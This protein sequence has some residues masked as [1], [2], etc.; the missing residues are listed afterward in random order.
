MWTCDVCQTREFHNYEAAISHEKSC[1]GKDKV[2]RV[3]EVL[4]HMNSSSKGVGTSAS[5]SASANTDS[6]V[7]ANTI[8]TATGTTPSSVLAVPTSTSTSTSTTAPTIVA[9]PPAT[10]PAL[11]IYIPPPIDNIPKGSVKPLMGNCFACDVCKKAYFRTYEDAVLHEDLCQKKHDR[12]VALAKYHKVHREFQLQQAAA[13]EVAKRKADA[14]EAAVISHRESLALQQ[15]AAIRRNSNGAN[16]NANGKSSQTQTQTPSISPRKAHAVAAE[17]SRRAELTLAEERRRNPGGKVAISPLKSYSKKTATSVGT[18]TSTGATSISTSQATGSGSGSGSGNHDVIVLDDDD[19]DDDHD[20]DD[21]SPSTAFET[22]TNDGGDADAD[23][24]P[25]PLNPKQRSSSLASSTMSSPRKEVPAISTKFCPMVQNTEDTNFSQLSS[26]HQYLV[27]YIDLYKRSDD[28]KKR[29]AFR[30]HFCKHPF[31][32]NAIGW[33]IDYAGRTLPNIAFSHFKHCSSITLRANQNMR[34]DTIVQSRDGGK[35]SFA[36]FM[37]MFCRKYLIEDS[38]DVGEGMHFPREESDSQSQSQVA[39]SVKRRLNPKEVQALYQTTFQALVGSKLK[40]TIT[41]E[42]FPFASEGVLPL[43]QH[44][45]PYHKTALE[46]LCFVVG[47]G[48]QDGRG[49]IIPA[50]Y[51]SVSVQCKHCSTIKPMHDLSKWDK[52]VLAFTMLHLG[53]T[54][55]SMPTEVREKMTEQRDESKDFVGNEDSP[56]LTLGQICDCVAVYYNFVDAKT[57]EKKSTPAVL[58]QF[59]K[60]EREH[61]EVKKRTVEE[62]GLYDTTAEGVA[63]KKKITAPVVIIPRVVESIDVDAEVDKTSNKGE[64]KDSKPAASTADVDLPRELIKYSQEGSTTHLVPFGGVPLLSS[65][66]LKNSAGLKPSQKMLLN[67]L[68]L[69]EEGAP[70]ATP[71]CKSVS[72]RCQNCNSVS[73]ESWVKTLTGVNDLYRQI[74]LAHVHYKECR[75]ASAEAK[76][77]IA[78]VGS[79]FS[80]SPTDPMRAYC[81][82]LKKVYGLEDSTSTNGNRVVIWADC[83]YEIG[84]YTCKDLDLKKKKSVAKASVPR[85]EDDDS[86]LDSV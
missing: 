20:H 43:V 3:D 84:E 44:L 2:L 63:R 12:Q 23:A 33:S 36:E 48:T 56:F 1:V 83:Q 72:L 26:F 76:Q 50:G 75:Y 71:G 62:A 37:R 15:Q 69:C 24:V 21:E 27:T 32:S 74:M 79:T 60:R 59:G 46:Q 45:T 77:N 35:L 22:N 52:T 53:N 67:N 81:D 86:S 30:C 16:A 82:F 4:T 47:K 28:S 61:K 10:N 7:N 6:N 65:V 40:P 78:S 39:E 17:A 58:V 34:S 70:L 57:I 5:A 13:A 11:N 38:D 54:C 8:A 73:S 66:T 31:P 55:H 64:D 41:T 68:E 9:H 14:A 85:L 29:V 42:Q 18:S 25:D 51:R 80:S 49:N 19:D